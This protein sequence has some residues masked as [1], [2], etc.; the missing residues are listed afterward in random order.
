MKIA[1]QGEVGS[2]SDGAASTFLPGRKVLPCATAHEVFEKLAGRAADAV[3]LPIENSLAGSVTQ[4][5]DLLLENEGWIE[6][7]FLLP[8]RHNLMAGPGVSLRQVRRVLSHPVALDQCREF[9]RKHPKIH[10]ETFYDTAGSVKHIV[11]NGLTDTAAI[12]GEQAAERYGAKILLRGIEDDKRNFTRFFLVR[13][14]RT[15][16]AGGN[17]TSVAF[18]LKNVPGALFKALSVF[19]LREIDL[20]RI[21][22]RPIR[23]RPWEYVFFV[24]YLRGEDE[25]SKK[26]LAHLGEISKFVKVLG[27]YPRAK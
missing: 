14:K 20:S 26:A 12:A 27:I 9:F 15:K 7:E 8:I 1:I 4:H 5:L 10:P 13:R 16:T 2:F 11:E 3:L 19:A 22:S 6:R 24:D 18:A 17:K 25:V 23:G 21:E